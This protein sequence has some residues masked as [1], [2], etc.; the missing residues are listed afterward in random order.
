MEKR[1]ISSL[2]FLYFLNSL[3]L[4]IFGAQLKMF[5]CV[6][7]RGLLEQ[8]AGLP[9]VINTKNWC[10]YN[11]FSASMGSPCCF[12]QQAMGPLQQR[13]EKSRTYDT[14]TV[15]PPL[16]FS[17]FHPFHTPLFLQP[18]SLHRSPAISPLRYS[19]PSLSE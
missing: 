13:S 14:H 16:L 17:P 18:S 5:S 6:C 12:K 1:S 10:N 9:S 2:R 4:L 11:E 8:S 7:V 3:C 15:F 19:S